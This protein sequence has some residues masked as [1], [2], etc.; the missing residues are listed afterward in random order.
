MSY[1]DKDQH[2]EDKE[3]YS[4]STESEHHEESALL[5]GDDET[6]KEP[7]MPCDGL[8]ELSEEG[9]N[10]SWQHLTY[11]V[12][13]REWF[14][15]KPPFVKPCW[16]QKTKTILSNLSGFAAAGN[17]H[18]CFRSYFLKYSCDQ[19]QGRLMAIMGPSGCVKQ[20]SWTSSPA[21]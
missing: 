10:L 15:K 21:V 7:K 12:S 14:S 8:L 4:H 3:E 18:F 5:A 20:L 17:Y 13:V 11:K 6:K 9:Y 1:S 16:T 2:I 19:P